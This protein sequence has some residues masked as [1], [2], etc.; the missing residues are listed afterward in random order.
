MRYSVNAGEM[1]RTN[2]SLI[3]D[4]IRKEGPISRNQIAR[5]LKLSVPTVLRIVKGLKDEELVREIKDN[6]V[7]RGH[8]QSLI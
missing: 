1:R 2:R 3:L 6:V 8:P 5:Q 4:S 7:R